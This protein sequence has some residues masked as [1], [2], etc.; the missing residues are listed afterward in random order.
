MLNRSAYAK[1]SLSHY[2]VTWDLPSTFDK[3][4]ELAT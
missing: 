3:C 4:E 2:Q 1:I